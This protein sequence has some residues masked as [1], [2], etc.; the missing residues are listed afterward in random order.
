MLFNCY[1]KEK[2][3]LI[4]RL[5][6]GFMLIQVCYMDAYVLIIKINTHTTMTSKSL[7]KKGLDE[8]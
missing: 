6:M 1:V 5:S 4:Q 3:Y 2:H 7:I 8:Q